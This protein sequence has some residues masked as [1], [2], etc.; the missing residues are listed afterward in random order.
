M[1]HVR[2][3]RVCSVYFIGELLSRSIEA[4][5]PNQGLRFS[6]VASPDCW[7]KPSKFIGDGDGDSD[8]V[9][10]DDADDDGVAAERQVDNEIY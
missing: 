5:G 3:F 1:L 4:G 8:V 6:F 7:T 10:V 9:D 2:S